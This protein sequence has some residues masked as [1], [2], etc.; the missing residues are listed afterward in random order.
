MIWL[1]YYGWGL[2][3]DLAAYIKPMLGIVIF[4]MALTLDFN[5]FIPALK[6]PKALI[7]GIIC[8][9]LFMP[10]L[11]FSIAKLFNFDSN[12]AIGLLLVGCAP[13][14]VTSNVI[15]YISKANLALSIAMTFCSTALAPIMLPFTMWVYASQWLEINTYKLFLSTFQIVVIPLVIGISIKKFSKLES[16]KFEAFASI[17]SILLVALII[18]AM[19]AVNID[20]ILSIENFASLLLVLFA[21]VVLHNFA[22]YLCG[23]YT[24][25]KLGLDPRDIRAICIEVGIQNSGLASV[26]ALSHF[27]PLTAVPT[28]FSGMWHAFSGSLLASYFS[29]KPYANMKT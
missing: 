28:V 1:G 5:D 13:G 2:S 20:K 11:A 10:A 17:T 16:K 22:G 21:A 4:A 19:V 14:G 18:H 9:Y 27:N 29:K 6:K 25:Q 3:K 7:I 24:A 8:Q 15:T 26:L 12:F 23:Y